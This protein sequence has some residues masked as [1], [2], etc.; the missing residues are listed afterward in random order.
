MS[1]L[2]ERDQGDAAALALERGDAA[3]GDRGDAPAVVG[4]EAD[5]VGRDRA[6]VAA[7][8]D[9]GGRAPVRSREDALKRVDRA[10][11][12]LD[13]RLAVRV[14]DDASV[15]PDAVPGRVTGL[16]LLTRAAD[17]PAD[18]DLPQGRV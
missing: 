5:D 15:A 6:D 12:Q 17:E 7:V 18:V 14:S 4:A 1:C 13:V 16:D 3:V 9:D 10:P 11:V 8:A 2:V